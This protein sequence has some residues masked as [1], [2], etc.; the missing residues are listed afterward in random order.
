M[1]TP[2]SLPACLPDP[3]CP[4]GASTPA[5][6]PPLGGHP[7]HPACP[8]PLRQACLTL[9][10]LLHHERWATC[11][12]VW[13]RAEM[14]HLGHMEL[15]S[16]AGKT[17]LLNPFRRHGAHGAGGGDAANAVAGTALTSA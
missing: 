14:E 13:H 10:C 8:S 5:L 16:V 1:A 12:Q 9:A 17:V 6:T 7:V 11:M 3:Y 4:R 15:E 2:I